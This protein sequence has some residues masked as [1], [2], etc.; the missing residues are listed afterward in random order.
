LQ[1]DLLVASCVIQICQEE[2]EKPHWGV[3]CLAG[4]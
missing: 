1:D 4:K 2:E 3:Q